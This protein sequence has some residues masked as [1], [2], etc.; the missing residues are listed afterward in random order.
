VEK[1]NVERFLSLSAVETEFAI[2]RDFHNQKA[3]KNQRKT[4]FSTKRI[5]NNNK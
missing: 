4:G 1:K 2:H 5:S 3:L